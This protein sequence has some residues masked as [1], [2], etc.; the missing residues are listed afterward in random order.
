L[1]IFPA[2]DIHAGHVVRASRR[3]LEG[4]TVHHADPIALAERYQ[5]EGARW[6]HVVDLDRAFAVGDQTPLLAALVKRLRVPVQ[7]GGGLWTLE[8][9]EEMRDI[10]VQRV[11]LGA[12]AI[13]TLPL[14]AA[15]TDQ[16]SPDS[17][18]LALDARDGRVWSRQWEE[19]AHWT[20][21]EIAD[22][23]R[24]AGVVTVVLTELSR[25]GGLGGADVDGAMAL[26]RAAGVE[27][28]VSGGVNGLDDLNRIR[29]AGLAGAVVG[30]GLLERRFTL[31]EALACSSS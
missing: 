9:V 3:G 27:V 5:D 30:R 25:E 19:A 10:G 23:A 16:L 29:A 21:L 4:A 7:V 24:A 15:I 31:P 12:R 20:P 11:L 6:L 18:G 28:I 17:L 26:A 1:E 22:L 8:A 13:A 14:L 2:I